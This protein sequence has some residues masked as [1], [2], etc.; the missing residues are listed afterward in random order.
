MKTKTKY[1][2]RVAEARE[3]T[4]RL[5]AAIEALPGYAEVAAEMEAAWAADELA[6]DFAER[7]AKARAEMEEAVAAAQA[8]RAASKAMEEAQTLAKLTQMEIAKRMGVSQPVVSNAKR[9]AVSVATLWRFF[10]ACGRELVITSIPKR[11][12]AH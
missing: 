2:Q 4:A 10:D 9:G 11:N 7:D 6:P 5:N 12:L 8:K 1:E 3:R